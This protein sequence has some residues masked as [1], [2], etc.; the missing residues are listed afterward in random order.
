MAGGVRVGDGELPGGPARRPRRLVRLGGEGVHVRL[1]IQEAGPVRAAA[2]PEAQRQGGRAGSRGRRDGDAEDA[3]A[4]PGRGRRAVH[5]GVRGMG[6]LSLKITPRDEGRRGRYKEETRMKSI[7]QRLAEKFEQLEEHGQ[8]TTV[9]EIIESR[10]PLEKKLAAAEKAL[11]ADLESS[12][13]RLAEAARRAFNITPKQAREFAR[14][15]SALDPFWES[16]KEM[17]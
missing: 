15:P 8:R 2:R 3:L 6:L 1:R 13:A 12:E 7:E 14:E 10:Q 9:I 11:G 5:P 17:D 16:V 4:G